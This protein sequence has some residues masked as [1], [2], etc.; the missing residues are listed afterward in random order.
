M[1]LPRLSVQFQ[2]AAEPLRK[3]VPSY[4]E[5]GRSLSDFMVLIPGLKKMP[6]S[7]ISKTINDIHLAL[8]HFDH[9]VVF[10]EFNIRLNLLWVSIRPIHG[11]RFEIVGA[12]QER[13]PEA[14]LVSHI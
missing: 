6:Q 11:I 14:R 2:D 12:I 5:N 8:T 1:K 9:A 3:R 4:D 10:A 13:V 7:M